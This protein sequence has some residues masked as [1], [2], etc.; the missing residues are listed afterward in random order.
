MCSLFYEL[1]KCKYIVNYNSE[2]IEFID[3]RVKN[4]NM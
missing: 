4:K 3:T 1:T 2:E